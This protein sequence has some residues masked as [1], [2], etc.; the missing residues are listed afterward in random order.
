MSQFEQS[1]V[2]TE[3]LNH[4]TKRFLYGLDLG[5]MTPAEEAAMAEI[6]A[7]IEAHPERE[8]WPSNDPL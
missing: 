6:A 2:S 7:E 4:L 1:R 8:Y 5:P 3:R